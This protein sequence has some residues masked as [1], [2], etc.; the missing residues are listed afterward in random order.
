MAKPIYSIE[1]IEAP[2]QLKNLPAPTRSVEVRATNTQGMVLITFHDSWRSAQW[3]RD[4]YRRLGY[5][6]IT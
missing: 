4:K 3:Q 6:D 5:T 1:A 2:I